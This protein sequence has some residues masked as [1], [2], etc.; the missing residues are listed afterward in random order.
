MK[1]WDSSE[2][3]YSSCVGEKG[4]YYHQSVV[5]PNAL[6]LL[7]NFHSLLDLGCGQGVLARHLNE[8]VDYLGVDL[9][10]E[11]IASAKKLTKN[12]NFL[13]ADAT[14]PIPVEKTDFDRA[15]FLL[16]L[17]NME[18][19][20]GAIQ[21]AARHLKK[22]GQL[23]IVLNHPC[24]R[25]PRQ[26]SW[27]VDEKMKLQYRRIN[28]YLSAQEIPI[29]TNPGKGAKS[30]TT[31]SYHH[32]LST[33]SSWLQNAKFAI[34]SMEEWC[35]DKK[36]EGSRARMEDR[37]RREIPLFLAIVAVKEG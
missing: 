18:K 37:A 20:E 22:N 16:S 33:Y 36:S 25:I 17:Q 14:Q 30:E 11:L 9:S 26:T 6:R 29:Q 31:F 24:F 4:H 12:R 13:V 3:W 10:K 23:L 8:K 15:S 32:P 7:G 5:I 21:T 34:M 19:G 2:K 1:N 27:D 28:S 35:S